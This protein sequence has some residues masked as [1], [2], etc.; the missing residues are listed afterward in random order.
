VSGDLSQDRVIT[1]APT[2]VTLTQGQIGTAQL[3]NLSLG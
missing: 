1:L 2:A 3:P